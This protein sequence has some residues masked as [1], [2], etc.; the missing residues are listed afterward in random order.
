MILVMVTAYFDITDADQYLHLFV[1]RG[2]KWKAFWDVSD[3]SSGPRPEPHPDPHSQ[4]HLLDLMLS[5]LR[6]V[7]A[8]GIFSF[9]VFLVG[10]C[11]KCCILAHENIRQVQLKHYVLVYLC[12]S[13]CSV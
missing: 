11:L 2:E 5:R 6:Y 7:M 13:H 3:S 4:P 1:M 12:L 9:C 8:Q 10:V